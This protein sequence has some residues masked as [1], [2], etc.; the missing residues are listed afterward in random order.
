MTGT[1]T[2]R[3]KEQG[4]RVHL[5]LSFFF[6]SSFFSL[7]YDFIK[8]TSEVIAEAEA[9]DAPAQTQTAA[10]DPQTEPTIPPRPRATSDHEARR[11]N[12]RK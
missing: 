8:A 11:G 10:V 2:H 12:S 1:E 9:K 6:F 7:F 5:F 4:P 3:E